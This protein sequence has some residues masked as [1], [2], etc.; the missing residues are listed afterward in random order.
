MDGK[1]LFLCSFF[2]VLNNMIG[3]IEIKFLCKFHRRRA[4]ETECLV[5]LTGFVSAVLFSI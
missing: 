2:C 1:A 5:G 4:I 3:V